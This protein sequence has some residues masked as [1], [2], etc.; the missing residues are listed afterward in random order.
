M[1][2]NVNVPHCLGHYLS[3]CAFRSHPVMVSDQIYPKEYVHVLTQ[4]LILFDEMKK[5]NVFGFFHKET[6]FGMEIRVTSQQCLFYGHS[7]TMGNF[8]VAAILGDV[9]PSSISNIQLIV[10]LLAAILV[11]R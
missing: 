8:H 5:I 4:H 7:S 10:M 3:T 2:N 11:H 6:L 9:A 1:T